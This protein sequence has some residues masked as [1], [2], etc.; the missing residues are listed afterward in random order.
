MA[1]GP[2]LILDRTIVVPQ[3]MGDRADGANVA[4][5]AQEQK[6]GAK[7]R[8]YYTSA[9]FYDKRHPRAAF[10][11]DDEGNAYLVVIDGRFKGQA[12]GASIYETAYVCHLLGMTDAIN[13]DGGGSTTLWTEKTGVINYPCDNKMFDHNGERSVP[14]LIVVY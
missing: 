4:A 3:I 7:I 8:T 14:N 6:Q 2:M 1:T 10:G 9:L 11:T 12:D 13:L 5:M